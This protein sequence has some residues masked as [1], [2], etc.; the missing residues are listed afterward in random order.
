LLGDQWT[1]SIVS[2]LHAWLFVGLDKL[3]LQT[4]S[5]SKDELDRQDSTRVH[6]A[7]SRCEE[8]NQ[9]IEIAQEHGWAFQAKAY[10][11]ADAA[12]ARAEAFAFQGAADRLAY[13]LHALTL[14]PQF[15]THPEIDATLRAA[16]AAGETYVE[17][18][19][20][21]PVRTWQAVRSSAPPEMPTL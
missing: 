17:A 18:M 1:S 8:I 13:M 3:A 11:V 9:A 15:D 5:W 2:G 19:S 12:L 21:I 20:R 14:T 7:I 16:H 4:P 6:Q 10:R